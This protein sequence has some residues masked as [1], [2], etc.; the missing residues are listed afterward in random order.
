MGWPPCPRQPSLP[1]VLETASWCRRRPRRDAPEAACLYTVSGSF[2][3]QTK[4]GH[5]S[6]GG[7]GLPRDFSQGLCG[8]LGQRPI[9]RGLSSF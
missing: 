8:V 3:G 1:G 4:T 9:V 2:W 6:G 5:T 7:Q